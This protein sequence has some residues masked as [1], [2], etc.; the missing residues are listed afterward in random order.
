MLKATIF[1]VLMVSSVTWS[2][3]KEKPVM[4]AEMAKISEA[5]TFERNGVTLPYR[6]FK[7]K[8]YDPKKTYP[9]YLALHGAGA[10]ATDN[11]RTLKQDVWSI[12]TLCSEAIRDKH[13]CFI[14]V[15]Q[16]PPMGSW[17]DLDWNHG[18]YKLA[19]VAPSDFMKLLVPL[20]EETRKEFKIDDKRMYVGGYSMGGYGTWDVVARNPNLFA[21]AV[22]VCGSGAPDCAASIKH[23]P[24]WIFHGEKDGVVPA[25]GSRE[26]YEALKNAGAPVKYTEFKGT[27]HNAWEPT[28]QTE[29]LV[30]WLFSQSK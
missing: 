15:P 6:L 11:Y 18:S 4:H 1:G 27:G 22:P 9:L 20:L 24:I 5:R 12:N 28:W 14:V 16:V 8:N 26:M 29:G 19:D 25:K 13:P 2:Q 23:L 10:R 21:A 3:A 17:V 30:D 7:P